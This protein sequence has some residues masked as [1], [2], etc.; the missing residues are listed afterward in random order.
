[1]LE[2]LVIMTLDSR[3]IFVNPRHIVSV[4]EARKADDPGKHYTNAV[5]CVISL[6]DGTHI[7]TAEECDSVER[8]L[9]DIAEKRLKEIR[10]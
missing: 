4:A 9:R 7:S 6:V 8:R 3:E 10:K 5:R 2:L 1:M